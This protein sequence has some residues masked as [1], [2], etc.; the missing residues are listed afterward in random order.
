M[1]ALLGESLD[2]LCANAILCL[3]G[4]QVNYG[5]IQ[6]VKGLD[7][8]VKA[9]ECV[10]LIGSNGAGKTTTLK[11]IT[12]LLPLHGGEIFLMDAIPKI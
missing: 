4:V 8:V 12:S 1:N 5:G 3:K 7:L 2:P 10:S 9:G 6:A 11:A